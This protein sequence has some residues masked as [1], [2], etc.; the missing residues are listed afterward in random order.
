MFKQPHLPSASQKVSSQKVQIC[1]WKHL[2]KEVRGCP[3]PAG[4][5]QTGRWI[6]TAAPGIPSQL[7]NRSL[8]PEHSW[9]FLQN[10]LQGNPQ[11]RGDGESDRGANALP[12]HSTVNWQQSSKL[13]VQRLIKPM[14][15]LSLA[16]TELL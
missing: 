6:L 15:M 12:D 2:W 16:C 4:K 13:V 8:S 14:H 11:S 7:V 9:C 1:S 3:N 10:A 5:T